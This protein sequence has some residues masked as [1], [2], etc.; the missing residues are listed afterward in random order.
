[1]LKKAILGEEVYLF[2]KF[3]D[4]KKHQLKIIVPFFEGNE[5]QMG[6]H[7]YR[8]QIKHRT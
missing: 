7:R 8:N 2:E 5:T 4:L 6:L 3:L 1:M